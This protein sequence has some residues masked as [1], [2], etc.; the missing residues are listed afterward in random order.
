MGTRPIDITGQKFSML[1]ALRFDHVHR[2]KRPNSGSHHH[3]LFQCDCGKTKVIRKTAVMTN[4]TKSCGCLGGRKDYTG[5]RSGKLIAIRFDKAQGSK[6]YWLFQCDCG[7][8]K[9][10]VASRV[11]RKGKPV[12]S[13]G[14]VNRKEK[15]GFRTRDANASK[16]SF[17]IVWT[18]MKQRCFNSNNNNNYKN[19][20]ARGISVCER[21]LSFKN[22][23]ED[24]YQP[25]LNHRKLHSHKN[26]TTIERVDNDGDYSPENCIWA[27]YVEQV[28][29]RRPNSPTSIKNAG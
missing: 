8:Q 18:G 22:F 11:F 14:C 2:C 23:A 21:W 15:H 29:N 25:Y 10:L 20:G 17:Y 19:Y 27:T 24:M 4:R 12:L 6:A 26:E 16:R 9:I 28:K 13:C 1:T 3:W 7:K 5:Q